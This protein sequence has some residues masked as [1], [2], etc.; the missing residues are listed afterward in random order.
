MRSRNTD[1]ILKSLAY[2]ITVFFLITACLAG[3]FS[4]TETES[5]FNFVRAID[6][7]NVLGISLNETIPNP[8]SDKWKGVKCNLKTATITEIR[9]ESLNLS[10]IIDADS[11]CKLQNLKVLSLAKNLI[12]GNIPDSISNCRKLVYLDLSSNLLTGKFPIALT[13]LKHL[14]ILNISENLEFKHSDNLQTTRQIYYL[15]KLLNVGEDS[16][17]PPSSDKPNSEM[18]E[19]YRSVKDLLPIIIGIPFIFALLVVIYSI[20][21]R[22]TKSAQNKKILKSLAQTPQNNNP[23]PEAKPD[24]DER[25]EL[26]FFVDEHETFKLDDLFEATANLQSHTHYSSQY[27]EPL[28]SEYGLTSFSESKKSPNLYISNGYT[29]P[30]KTSSEQGDVFSFGIILLELLTGKTVENSG[31]DLPKWVR[32][33][34]REEWTG[35][36]FDKEVNKSGREFAFPLLNI[37][38]K[39]VSNSPEDRPT[40]AEITEKIEEIGD[41]DVSISSMASIESSTRECCLLHTVIPE[42]WDTPGSNY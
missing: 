33:M 16:A 11:L 2:T 19:W 28:I 27:K 26:V 4:E 34:V 8:C 37:A 31:I 18:K 25:T 36:V 7:E 22:A 42:A 6:P 35:E 1:Q 38:L 14:R 39:C 5:F 40:M 29:A 24:E 20:N 13:K 21:A 30:E 17:Q 41:D 10:G 23:P 32:S 3:E 12:R 15:R 9:L